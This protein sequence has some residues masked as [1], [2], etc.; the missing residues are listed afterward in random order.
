MNVTPLRDAFAAGLVLLALLV[1]PFYYGGT[2]GAWAIGIASAAALLGVSLT[3]GSVLRANGR[4]VRAARAVAGVALAGLAVLFQFSL[5]PETSLAPTWAVALLPLAF[6]VTSALQPAARRG[7]VAAVVA[8]VGAVATIACVRFVALGERATLPLIDPNNF[9]TLM[10]LVWIPL[11]HAHLARAASAGRVVHAAVLGATFVLTLALFA[12]E[13]RGGNLVVAVALAIWL[14]L[15]SIR[16]LPWRSVLAVAAVAALAFA[17]AHRKGLGDALDWSGSA[18]QGGAV[19]V[20]IA[21][22]QVAWDIWLEHPLTGVGLAC[23]RLLYA[24]LRPTWEQATLGAFVHNDYVQLL[25]EGGVLLPL[26]ALCL[27][28]GAAW[29]SV[30]AWRAAPDS[31]EFARGGL[32]M[33]LAAA[34]GH[35]VINFTF[36]MAPLAILIGI[37]AGA[38]WHGEPR[39]DRAAAPRASKGVIAGGLLFSWL[40]W[41]SFALD[42]MTWG[43]FY[44]E[45]VPGAAWIGAQPDRALAYAR[46]ATTL[47]GE[48]AVPWLG[49]ASIRH[50]LA[51]R[52]PDSVFLRERA[53]A[54][55]RCAIE[56]DPWNPVAYINM[57]RHVAAFP[58]LGS[59]LRDGETEEALLLSALGVDPTNVEAVESLR[60]LYERAG[61]PHRY[62]ALLKTVVLPR[63]ESFQRNGADVVQRYMDELQSI[64]RSEGDA[65]LLARVER[66]RERLKGIAPVRLRVWGGG[67]TPAR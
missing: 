60:S 45:P 18:D 65:L 24:V 67:F 25:A 31:A 8:V 55:F 22:I 41:A 34:C 44:G 43:V 9:T 66:E 61:E 50:Q 57:A 19:G 11:V 42:N 20:R 2:I 23:F 12:A 6:L 1:S 10:Y 38:L 3:A 13:S 16:R 30:R 46:I 14:G 63:L 39:S 4:S 28:A 15:A 37:V 35:A 33:G 27:G 26:V 29:A 32:A 62:A 48:R 54:E 17:V 40:A 56:I 21:M 36:Y 49:A 53:L 64:A 5:S 52:E 58:A 59:R 47:N 51:M 7:L